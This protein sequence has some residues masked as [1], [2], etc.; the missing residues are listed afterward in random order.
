MQGRWSPK[1]LFR[2]FLVRCLA[3]RLEASTR[4]LSLVLETSASG[5]G[6]GPG[7]SRR[8]PNRSPTFREGPA[9]RCGLVDTLVRECPW[10]CAVCVTVVIESSLTGPRAAANKLSERCGSHR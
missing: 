1:G 9:P 3:E 7:V 4:S 5:I 2:Q 10:C 8:A 6:S